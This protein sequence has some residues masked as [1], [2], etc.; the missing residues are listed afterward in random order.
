MDRHLHKVY[1][2]LPDP[3][4]VVAA[5]PV[6]GQPKRSLP[7]KRHRPCQLW[8]TW[9]R[10]VLDHGSEGAMSD[11]DK[12]TNIQINETKRFFSFNKG[13]KEQAF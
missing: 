3:W 11:Q 5:D 4:G 2:F 1:L 7:C 8:G 9:P 12:A 6:R 10:T 13:E